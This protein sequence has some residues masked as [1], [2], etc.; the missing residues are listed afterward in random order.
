[1]NVIKKTLKSLYWESKNVS[2]CDKQIYDL[3]NDYKSKK[4]EEGI[5]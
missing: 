3:K 4:L 5:F 2:F 1:M